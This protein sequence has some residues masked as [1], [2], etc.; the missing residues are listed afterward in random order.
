VPGQVYEQPIESL[1][2]LTAELAAELLRQGYTTA[3]VCHLPGVLPDPTSLPLNVTGIASTVNHQL[4][5]DEPAN[6][7]LKDS[8]GAA[9]YAILNGFLYDLQGERPEIIHGL[10]Y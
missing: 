3:R 8:E 5:L 2:E 1:D 10:H 9:K 6:F 4:A 7:L